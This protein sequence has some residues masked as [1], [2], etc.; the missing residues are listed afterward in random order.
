MKAKNNKK[1]YLNQS[2]V[3]GLSVKSAALDSAL[4]SLSERTIR[5]VTVQTAELR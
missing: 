2:G 4:C 5:C 3:N 1:P